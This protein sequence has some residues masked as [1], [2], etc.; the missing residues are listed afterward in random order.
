MKLLLQHHPNPTWSLQDVEKGEPATAL[1]FAEACETAA[2][3]ACAELIR[4]GV[5]V[6]WDVW[7]A[8]PRTLITS[9]KRAIHT[10]ASLL[11]ATE[12]GKALAPSTAVIYACA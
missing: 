10:K 9:L 3:A 11:A 6:R 1:E 8:L 5:D 7:M 2:G 12:A 4:Q